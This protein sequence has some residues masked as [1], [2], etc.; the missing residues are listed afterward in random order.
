M[1][2]GI[3]EIREIRDDKNGAETV[4]SLLE[5]GWKFISACQVGTLDAMDIVYVV[6]ATKEV[7]D[8]ESKDNDGTSCFREILNRS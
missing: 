1:Y 2:D 3:V 7:I 4:N 6:G 8:N 5:R